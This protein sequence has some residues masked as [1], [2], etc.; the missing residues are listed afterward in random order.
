MR[1]FTY[2][3][4]QILFFHTIL[5]AQVSKKAIWSDSDKKLLIEGLKSSKLD[6]MKELDSVNEVQFTF[7]ADSSKW[8]IKEV[9]EHLAVY[10]EYLNWDLVYAVYSPARPDLIKKVS[11][12]DEV[13]V[14]YETDPNKGHAPWL[15]H[16]L[17]RFE[18]KVDLINYHNKF[19]DSIINFL[20][21][22][23]EDLR[24]HFIYRAPESGSWSVK[25]LHQQTLLFIAHTRRH[26]DQIR[27]IKQEK[28]Y[29]ANGKLWTE[30]DRQYILENFRRA[31]N[32]LIKETENLTTTQWI[33]RESTGRWTIAEIVEHLGI[34]ERVW[35]RQINMASRNRPQPELNRIAKAD[36]FYNGWI[37]EEK[38]HTAP[39][40]AVPTGLINDKSNLTFFLKQN[41]INIK[42]VETTK[43]DMRAYF[44]QTNTDPRNLHHVLIFQWG[45]IDRHLRQ[46]RK[47]KADPNYPK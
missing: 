10:D 28:N 6:L 18:R 33:F 7:K 38:P 2:L 32:E 20:Q 22:T 12:K 39:D 1:A 16:P 27:R 23:K 35:S 46:I 11:G 37:M 15:A 9:L 25:D 41:D 13:M 43:V 31:R 45:H 14:A 29:P 44:E 36:S 34:W 19:R 17:G 5:S 30:S 4:I 42:F 3:L 47:V 40:F 21:T 8:S 24:L 26:T